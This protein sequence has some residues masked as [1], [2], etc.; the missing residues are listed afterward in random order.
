MHQKVYYSKNFKD[1]ITG[2]HTNTIEG[3]W[4][5]LKDVIKKVH[6]WVSSGYIFY[7]C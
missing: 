7:R 2:I 3:N 6:A 1:P 5:A 4:S